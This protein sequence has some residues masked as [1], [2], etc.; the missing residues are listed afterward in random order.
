MDVLIIRF[1]LLSLCQIF[2]Y[3]YADVYM[4]M[5]KYIYIYICMR[6]HVYA[7]RLYNMHIIYFPDVEHFIYSDIVMIIS[8]PNPVVLI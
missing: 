8:N 4:H 6:I 5:R 3:P 2:L 7:V 1:H